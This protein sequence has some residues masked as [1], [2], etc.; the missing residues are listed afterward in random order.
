M[1]KQ[2]FLEDSL[3]KFPEKEKFIQREIQSVEDRMD[4]ILMCLE[5]IEEW[6]ESC[7]GF[8]AEDKSPCSH[9]ED[10][11]YWRTKAR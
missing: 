1:A 9:E 6:P 11:P 3:R 4:A 7:V 10:C 5:F 8:C 2:S